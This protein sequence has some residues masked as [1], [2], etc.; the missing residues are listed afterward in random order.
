MNSRALRSLLAAAL[1]AGVALAAAGCSAIGAVTK[2]AGQVTGHRELVEAGESMER[3][4]R[5]FN[6][7]EKYWVGRTV[8]A[9]LLASRHPSDRRAVELYLGRVGQTV[10]LASG[11]PVLPK[12]WHFILLSGKT[13]EA[14]SCPGGTVMVGEGALALARTEDELAAILAHEAAHVALDH[15][16]GAISSANRKAAMVKLLQFGASQ[17]AAHNNLSELTDVFD[18]VISEVGNAVAKGYDR[19]TEAATDKAAVAILAELGYD[20]KALGA[21]L[22]R[23]PKGS[24]AHGDPKVRAKEALAEA[25][26]FPAPPP[27]EIRKARFE[28][29]IATK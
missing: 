20:P 1:A 5:D 9:T 15:P 18:N 2:V 4:D 22:A 27:P 7:E 10:A 12:G 25:A 6:E 11:K 29:A 16:M 8:A 3:S 17:A 14:F 23:I 19:S 13:P 21:V 28:A 24:A 26:K